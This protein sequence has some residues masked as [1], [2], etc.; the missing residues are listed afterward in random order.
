[1]EIYSTVLRWVGRESLRK[2]IQ[3]EKN[4]YLKVSLQAY[5]KM[6]EEQQT[7]HIT[8][9]RGAMCKMALRNI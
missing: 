9:A 3:A 2:T 4:K 5:Y 7:V 6:F 8:G 1:M